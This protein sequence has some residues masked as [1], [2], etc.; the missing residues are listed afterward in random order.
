MSK[1][2]P[3]H[4]NDVLP[5]RLDEEIRRDEAESQENMRKELQERSRSGNYSRASDPELNI[6]YNTYDADVEF[7]DV[8]DEL[9][10]IDSRILKKEYDKDGGI[11]AEYVGD[12]EF[13]LRK[14]MEW[15][16]SPEEVFDVRKIDVAADEIQLW[17][18]V[19]WVAGYSGFEEDKCEFG[20]FDS[21]E[22]PPLRYA[23]VRIDNEGSESLFDYSIIESSRY[24]PQAKLDQY[25]EDGAYPQEVLEEG[26]DSF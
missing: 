8:L 1:Q 18:D 5:L 14:Y 21:F 11:S 6:S 24:H 16:F 20:P 17:N 12:G 25:T 23:N 19:Y 3:E 15:F 13:D 22:G 9:D 26:P 10:G 7:E 4:R 2:V